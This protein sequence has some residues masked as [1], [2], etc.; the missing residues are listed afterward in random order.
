[1]GFAF[2]DCDL[3]SA[4]SPGHAPHVHLSAVELHQFLD[5][6]QTDAGAFVGPSPRPFDSVEALED[7][8]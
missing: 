7:V 8:R 4:A 1:M 2:E 3:E 5:Q 6:S